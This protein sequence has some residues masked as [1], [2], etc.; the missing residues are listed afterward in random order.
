MNQETRDCQNCKNKFVIETEDFAFYQK[1]EVPPPTWCPDCMTQR[2]FCW[3][4]E[5]SLYR[6]KYPTSGQD[7]ITIF[8]PDSPFTVY[9]M[10]TWWSDSWDS[11]EYGQ[12]YDF[13]KPFFQQ[14]RELFEK[15]PLAP[16][17]NTNQVRSE[18]CNHVEDMK[19][20]YLTFASIWCEAVLY[21]YQAIHCKDSMDILF[22]D[23]SELI[24]E[25]INCENCYRLLF[26]KNCTSCNN[27]AFLL[28]CSGCSNC[29]GCVN[30][31]NKS[32]Y[33][34][35]EPY[36]PQEYK[37]KMKEFPLHSFSEIEKVKNKFAEFAEL[38]PRKYAHLINS[39][40]STGNVLYDAKNCTA[41][42]NLVNNVENCKYMINGGY[43]LKDSQYGYGV[44]LG[45]L[46]Y[47]VLDTGIGGQK[48]FASV[49]ERNG[50]NINYAFN[51]HGSSNIFG[52][53]G[54][55]SRNYC[56]LNKQY[57]KEEYRVLIPKI[58]E[59]MNSMP[60]RDA[61]GREYRYGEF[62]PAEISPFAYNETIAQ[63]HFPLTK[64]EAAAQGYRWKNPEEKSYASALKPESLPD[65]IDDVK[66]D[67]IKEIIACTHAGSCSEQCTFAF[68]II[69]EELAFYRNLKLPLPRLCPNCRHYRR[70]IERNPLKLWHR[71]CMC[72]GTQSR[73]SRSQVVCK[74]QT[75]H[76]HGKVYCPN[77]FET[78][79]SPENR[80]IVYCE[81][82]YQAEVV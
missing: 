45:E 7:F 71:K 70:L 58:I 22:G 77:E 59:H 57:S 82:C 64:E 52:C 16:L 81:Q 28:D 26:S 73:E 40:N 2:L 51:C 80:E 12:A 69:P 11:M 9:D 34:F 29:F 78:I 43:G 4:N 39:P 56:V 21:S 42:F 49:V 14:F 41:C 32:Y 37:E 6:R 35:N 24:Y 72:A 48:I 60:Y 23:K 46:M 79:F 54:V 1:M 65:R 63:E 66:D 10:K 30:L 36:L 17:F 3:R 47:Q 62:F 27:S 18:Y 13:S 25:S 31:R 61:R 76:F 50:I 68:R 5:R 8:A 53:I 74:N 44:G 55:R 33:I 20:C 38:F 67:I 15:V 75:E 19:D